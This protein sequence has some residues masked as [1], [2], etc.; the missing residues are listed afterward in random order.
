MKSSIIRGCTLFCT[1]VIFGN[2]IFFSQNLNQ[3]Q[4]ENTM[5]LPE[6]TTY[7]PSSLENKITIKSEQIQK[8]HYQ[9]ILQLLSENSV[10]ILSYGDYGLEQKP[11]IRGFTDE[12]VRVVIDGVCMNNP[13]TGTFDFSSINIINIEEISIIKGGYNEGTEDEGA[14]G[15][16]IYITTKKNYN[17]TI[18]FDT[19]I[20]TFFN[21][22]TPL[23]LFSQNFQFSIP[24]SQNIFFNLDLAA[25]KANNNF[26][27]NNSKVHD[28]HSNIN[29]TSYFGNGNSFSISDFSYLGFKNLPGPAYSQNL[30]KQQDFQNKLTLTLFSPNVSHFFTLKNHLSWNFSQR[31][32][33]SKTETSNHKLNDFSL[34]TFFDFFTVRNFKQKAGFTLDY[35]FLDSTNTGRHQN[36]SFTAK[37]TSQIKFNSVISLSI[38]FGFK[39]NN[40]NFSVL[41]KL[42]LSFDFHE[43]T[44]NLPLQIILNAY[45]L[46]QF[47]TMDDLYWHG[48]NF[49]GN[50]NLKPENGY[51]SEISFNFD[52][53]T[54]KTSENNFNINFFTVFYENKIQWANNNNLWQPKNVASAFYFGIDFSLATNFFQNHLK[55]S[56]NA[57]YL[58]TKLLDKTNRQ[59]YGK[60]IMWT[61]DFT[62]STQISVNFTKWNA[63][64]GA[65]YTGKRYISNLNISYLKPYVLLSLT[66]EFHP[67]QKI[68]FY[69]RGDNLLNTKYESI[70]NYKMPGINAT[71]GVKI[72]L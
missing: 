60:K 26:Q 2:S 72:L 45:K 32:Y 23:D 43:L 10:Q 36:F 48:V 49:T 68:N 65:S 50:E 17:K 16:V 33:Q 41:P 67:I 55:F 35:V 11:S 30:E 29:L 5:V 20:K 42:A 71:F 12:T 28:A 4:T 53:S 39:F 37:E 56:L 54:V 24:F 63:T 19:K 13:Q 59:T 52:F 8:Q 69:I 44:E 34:S 3:S 22:E 38:P 58:Y 14:V 62:C 21:P 9:N 61:P 70:E 31:S 57:E 1:S 51:G 64:F 46:T 15:G 25:T 27:S 7:I 66:A 40:K 6:I 18:L 47:P